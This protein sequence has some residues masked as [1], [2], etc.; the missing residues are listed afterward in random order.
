[1]DGVIL[2]CKNTY[3]GGLEP[4]P[5]ERL[6]ALEYYDGPTRGVI[7]CRDCEQAYI[8]TML[9]IDDEGK[10]DRASWNEG[11]EIRVFGLSDLPASS[12]EELMRVCS[13]YVAPTWPVWLPLFQTTHTSEILN[14]VKSEMQHVL[15]TTV[16]VSVVA[17]HDL[18]ADVVAARN[19]SEDDPAGMPDWFSFL[20]LIEDPGHVT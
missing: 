17:T 6:I 10:Y 1:M 3:S 12:F 14:A 11:R 18:L 5:F 8:F 2:C 15:D 13:R 20:G 4:S 9:D 19:I 7:Q 16:V